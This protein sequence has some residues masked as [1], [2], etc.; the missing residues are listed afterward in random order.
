[1][2]QIK[3]KLGNLGKEV[4]SADETAIGTWIDGKTIYRKCIVNNGSGYGTAITLSVDLSNVDKIIEFH[5]TTMMGTAEIP[6]QYSDAGTYFNI[7]RVGGTITIAARD[8]GRSPELT[9]IFIFMDY[10]KKTE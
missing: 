4:Y 2:A 6:L 7:Y 3:Y 9:K 10:T 1:M 5:G 8:S